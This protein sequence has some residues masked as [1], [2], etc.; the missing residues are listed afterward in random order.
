MSQDSSFIRVEGDPSSGLLFVCDH[1]GREVPPAYRALGLLQDAFDRHIAFDIGAAEVTKLLAKEFNAP[2]LF[3]R[4]SRLLIDLNR[5]SDDPTL[6]M[7]VSDGMI[8]TGNAGIGAD[9]I[10]KRIANFHAPYH[11]AI[12]G[13]IAAQ[14]ATGKPPALVSVHSFTPVWKGAPRPWHLAVLSSPKDRRLSDLILKQL[15]SQ[16]GLVIGDNEPYSGDLKGD[17]L[18]QHGLQEALPHALIEIRQDLIEDGAGQQKIASLLSLLLRNA[19]IEFEAQ[20]GT[21]PALLER[22]R[23][24]MEASAF[25]RL[26][27]HLR[28]RTDVQNIDLMNLA[29]FCRNCLGD[30]FREAG[31]PLG[32]SLSKDQGREAVYGMS[33]AEWKA[34]YQ[35]EASAEQKAAFAQ[36]NPHKH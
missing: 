36:A 8:I 5:A 17:T 11:R 27:K 26:I 28:Q 6:V 1:A 15:R 35:T 29:G 7:P 30:W 18:D 10:A 33:P 23:E 13:Q 34:R 21:V 20:G 12:K 16:P 9:E 25:R 3:G 24:A 32:V 4:Y 19:L 14:R 31:E 2:A 22:E